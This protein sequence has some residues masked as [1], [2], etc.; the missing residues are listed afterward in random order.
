MV[1]ERPIVLS[2]FGSLVRHGYPTGLS[3]NLLGVRHA[4]LING[5]PAVTAQ[6]AVAREWLRLPIPKVPTSSH[7]GR[8]TLDNHV[9]G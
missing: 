6:I 1:S 4:L 2:T 3:V 8:S 7:P 9:T 5:I